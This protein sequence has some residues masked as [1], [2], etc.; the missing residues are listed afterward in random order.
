MKKIILGILLL[1]SINSFSNN[2]FPIS[3]YKG[4]PHLPYK[5]IFIYFHTN[6]DDS[7][8][9][10]SFQKKPDGWYVIEYFPANDTEKK[11]ELPWSLKT[12]EFQKIKIPQRQKTKIVEFDSSAHKS[13][14][15]KTCLFYGYRE[16]STDVINIMEKEPLL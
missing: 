16:W 9:P 6:Y 3:Y 5:E 14:L 4:N 8:I 15:F 11:P 2:S 12:K 10:S 1:I 13:Y 7:E